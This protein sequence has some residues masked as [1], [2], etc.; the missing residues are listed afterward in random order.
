MRRCLAFVIALAAAGGL[1]GCGSSGGAGRVPGMGRAEELYEAGHQYEQEKN[2]DSAAA[3]LERAVAADSGFTPALSEYADVQYDRGMAITDTKS[4]ARILLLLSSRGALG[5]LETLTA[6]DAGV[7]DRLCELSVALGD[8]RSFLFYARKSAGKFPYERQYYNLGVALYQTGDYHGAVKAM[9]EAID[10]FA[11]S[12]YTGGFY[13][14][15][16]LAYMKLDRDQTA[17][18]TFESGVAAVDNLLKGMKQ[19]DPAAPEVRRLSDDRT[20]MLL[21]LRKL[22]TTYQDQENLERVEKLLRQ[23]GNLK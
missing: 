14:E 10:K 9:K 1:A 20:G 2:L 11:A 3:L 15:E 19:A 13:R 23:S 5:R 21:S 12:T 7:Y 8:S 16:G 17:T 4:P 6:A 18:R 22:Y